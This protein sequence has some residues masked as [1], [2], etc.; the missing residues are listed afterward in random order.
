MERVTQNHLLQSMHKSASRRSPRETQSITVESVVLDVRPW[1][2]WSFLQCSFSWLRWERLSEKQP[3]P[4]GAILWSQCTSDSLMLVSSTAVRAVVLPSQ[5]HAEAFVLWQHKVRFF[6]TIGAQV[7]NSSLPTISNAAKWFAAQISKNVLRLQ[8]VPLL[9]ANRRFMQRTDLVEGCL[10]VG[11]RFLPDAGAAVSLLQCLNFAER[12]KV[13]LHSILRSPVNGAVTP[14]IVSPQLAT[15]MLLSDTAHVTWEDALQV[16]QLLRERAA[17]RDEPPCDSLDIT[18]ERLL[19]SLHIPKVKQGLMELVDGLEPSASDGR[20]PHTAALHDCR[21]RLGA[22]FARY[23]QW[24]M[25]YSLLKSEEMCDE[26]ST[27]GLFEVGDWHEALRLAC[28]SGA[29]ERQRELTMR[30]L[31]AE[32]RT[33]LA[34]HWLQH[35]GT[36]TLRQETVALLLV[37]LARKKT[38]AKE[39]S[40]YHTA[41]DNVV[42]RLDP[43]NASQLAP[44]SLCA[45][46]VAIASALAACGMWERVLQLLPRSLKFDNS[47]A[48]DAAVD[49]LSIFVAAASGGAPWDVLKSGITSLWNSNSCTHWAPGTL[50]ELLV[51]CALETGQWSDALELFSAHKTQLPLCLSQLNHPSLVGKCVSARIPFSC[52]TFLAAHKWQE[53]LRVE[54]QS[55][56]VPAMTRGYCMERPEL[57]EASLCISSNDSRAKMQLGMSLCSDRLLWFRGIEILDDVLRLE[58]KRMKQLIVTCAARSCAAHRPDAALALLRRLTS[59]YGGDTTQEEV[60]AAEMLHYPLRRPSQLTLDILIKAAT[61]APTGDGR[62]ESWAAGIRLITASPTVRPSVQMF[63]AALESFVNFR[64]VQELRVTSHASTHD[65]NRSLLCILRLVAPLSGRRRSVPTSNR[66]LVLLFSACGRGP[67][68]PVRSDERDNEEVKE[69]LTTNRVEADRRPHQQWLKAAQIL[70]APQPSCRFLTL[71]WRQLGHCPPSIVDAL[72]S[73][74]MQVA[75]PASIGSWIDAATRC[76]KW[77]TAV[78]IVQSSARYGMIPDL[79]S[80]VNLIED[81]AEESAANPAASLSLMHCSKAIREYSPSNATAVFRAFAERSAMFADR[82]WKGSLCVLSNLALAGV[83]N[84]PPSVIECIATIAPLPAVRTAL[85]MMDPICVSEPTP[86][87]LEIAAVRRVVESAEAVG[88]RPQVDVIYTTELPSGGS[89]VSLLSTSNAELMTRGGPQ[90]AIKKLYRE[91]LS[92]LWHVALGIMAADLSR[93]TPREASRVLLLT[94]FGCKDAAVVSELAG[95]VAPSCKSARSARCKGCATTMQPNLITQKR[96][97]ALKI[98]TNV[99]HP[100]SSM[101]AFCCAAAVLAHRGRWEKSLLLIDDLIKLHTERQ[102]PVPPLVTLLRISALNCSG[103]FDET[104]RVLLAETSRR[105]HCRLP[106]PPREV[107]LWMKECG[108]GS[109]DC[110]FGWWKLK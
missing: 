5:R 9:L 29:S 83:R 110:S 41:I 84:F 6:L 16:L 90:G 106:M 96:G 59:R 103:R 60:A 86:I 46:N 93:S 22:L 32:R 94:A 99:A 92:G 82:S 50:R 33:L 63:M 34:C 45:T 76:G 11:S 105:Y 89:R 23:G 77:E 10:S 67:Y 69:M 102:T 3:P 88:L 56:A 17:Q 51:R 64:Y 24:G 37:Q 100:R 47:P 27:R 80:L 19:P 109:T 30:L 13:I 98:E 74:T 18:V 91:R 42:K 52:G 49:P 81:R 25:A 48:A 26:I 68:S 2:V 44:E 43:I 70:M 72:L 101:V 58:C 53:A 40:Y 71:P 79:A 1:S 87:T 31:V 54:L 15:A 20:I 35:G 61:T 85:G 8:D 75:T 104:M 57:W 73:T 21:R 97:G 12:R 78:T 38:D 65:A 39:I 4:N 28:S 55:R 7:H 95:R 62:N 108:L 14:S 66:R 36:F 107:R